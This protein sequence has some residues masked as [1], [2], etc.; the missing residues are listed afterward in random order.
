MII[1]HSLFMG[2]NQLDKTDLG[3]DALYWELSLEQSAK[4]ETIQN[5]HHQ[6]LAEASAAIQR[7][8]KVNWCKQQDMRKPSRNHAPGSA[9]WM[10]W[11]CFGFL[12]CI[13]RDHN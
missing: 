11:E 13:L 8:M 9:E 12:G 10:A 3:G 7:V 2:P 1:A 4:T 5:L 6:E